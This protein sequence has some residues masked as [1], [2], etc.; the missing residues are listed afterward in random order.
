MNGLISL[1]DAVIGCGHTQH[2]VREKSLNKFDREFTE[3]AATLESDEDYQNLLKFFIGTTK[4]M[5][6]SNKW[7][8]RFGAIQIS[9]KLLQ[10]IKAERA[11]ELLT[12]LKTYLFDQC[13]VLLNDQ[14]FRVRNSIGDIMQELIKFD[15]GQ[16]YKDFKDGLFK[17]IWDTFNRDPKGSDAS[18]EVT[19][20]KLIF[21]FKLYF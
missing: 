2:L 14:E 15:G 13:K 8:F 17:N 10:K 1:H 16:V 7:E 12:Y 20:G 18:S 3:A 4:L 19:Q 21:S 5:F 6:T 9:V 11:S